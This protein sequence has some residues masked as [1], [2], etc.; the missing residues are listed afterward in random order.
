MKKLKAHPE[1]L[2]VAARASKIKEGTLR[3]FVCKTQISKNKRKS[4]EKN[5]VSQILR[6]LFCEEYC[7][8]SLLITCNLA[9]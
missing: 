8:L 6:C 3:R 2:L 5:E 4:T 1:D 7:L 9:Y